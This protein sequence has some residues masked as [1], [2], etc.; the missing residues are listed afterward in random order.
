M[1]FAPTRQDERQLA[2]VHPDLRKVV[3]AVFATSPTPFRVLEG[4]RTRDQQRKNIAAGVSWTMNSRHIAGRN[5]WAHAVDLTPLVNGDPSWDWAVYRQFV[6]IVRAAATSVGVPLEWGGDWQKTPDAPH[7]QLPRAPK[8]AAMGVPVGEP[9]DCCGALRS[10]M[11][12]SEASSPE[13]PDGSP[14]AT[15]PGKWAAALFG[16][17]GFGLMGGYGYGMP[18]IV[19][20]G[21]A[22]LL[23]LGVVGFLVAIGHGRRERLWDRMVGGLLK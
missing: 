7:W 17:G 14:P 6:P 4:A 12:D 2:K 13:N 11:I 8:Y 10:Q 16:G 3:D 20:A 21:I 18:P 19:M 1:S 5:G 15:G 23:A 9:D 22:I